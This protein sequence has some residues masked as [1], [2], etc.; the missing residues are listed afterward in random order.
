[1]LTPASSFSLLASRFSLSCRPWEIGATPTHVACVTATPLPLRFREF[2]RDEAFVQGLELI[3]KPLLPGSAVGLRLDEARP[4][5][6]CNQRIG[7]LA[8]TE[9]HDPTGLW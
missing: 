1:V 7:C 4:L 3:S 6:V 9:V 5:P 8:I 2:P